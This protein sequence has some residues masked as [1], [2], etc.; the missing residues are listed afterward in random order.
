[1]RCEVR[2]YNSARH[3]H[4]RGRRASSTPQ[5][6]PL[7]SRDLWTR[8]GAARIGAVD[9][10]HPMALARRSQDR[11]LTTADTGS[12]C[13]QQHAGDGG[14]GGHHL[15]FPSGVVLSDEQVIA[16][17]TSDSLQRQFGIGGP[18]RGRIASMAKRTTI[19][20]VSG[21]KRA[22]CRTPSSTSSAWRCVPERRLPSQGV[23]APASRPCC[24]AW[25]APTDQTMAACRFAVTPCRSL[26]GDQARRCHGDR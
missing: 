3:P 5:D 21:P 22:F 26:T 2:S 9:P 6:V 8:L 20:K 10:P 24:A 12:E 18:G 16:C 13:R 15:C 11:Y 1:M 17:L 14:D 7:P 19:L 23:M 25:L 4:G